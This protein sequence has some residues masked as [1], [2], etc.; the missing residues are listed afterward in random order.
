MKFLEAV[1]LQLCKAEHPALH[2]VEVIFPAVRPVSPFLQALSRQLGK[3]SLA[4]ACFAL[5]DWAYRRSGLRRANR[6]HLISL[7]HQAYLYA[8]DQ[9]G[10]TADTPEQ[11]LAWA[12]GLLSDFEEVDAYVLPTEAHPVAAEQIFRYLSQQK[13]VEI[14]NPS[15]EE[16]SQAEAE[17]LRFYNLI[18]PTYLEFRRLLETEKVDY[19]SGALRK[20]L[21]SLSES[22]GRNDLVDAMFWVGFD[23]VSPLLQ[24]II[25]TLHSSTKIHWITDADRYY[26]DNPVHLA[27]HG[28]RQIPNDEPFAGAMPAI[29]RLVA[30]IPQLNQCSCTGTM[31]EIDAGIDQIKTWLASGVKPRQIGWVL[32]ESAQ[33][34]P[35]LMRWDHTEI[36][37][38]LGMPIDLRWTLSYSWAMEYLEILQSLHFKGKVTLEDWSNWVNNPIWPNLNVKSIENQNISHKRA[39][40]LHANDLQSYQYYDIPLIPIAAEQSDLDLQP[41]K[42]SHDTKDKATQAYL[43]LARIASA[44]INAKESKIPPME[45]HALRSLIT[46]IKEI[47]ARLLPSKNSWAVWRKMWSM[48]LSSAGLNPEGDS[49]EGIRLMSLSDTLA[50]DFD[51]MV[52]SGLNEGVMPR[53][54]HYKGMLSFDLRRS[55]GLPESWIQEAHQTYAFYRLL[56]HC[57][58]AK[59]LYI[60]SGVGGKV[61]EKSR[62]LQ[63]LDLEYDG[64]LHESRKELPM[65]FPTLV[66]DAITITKTKDVL[67]LILQKLH[68]KSI[69]PSYLSSYLICP[70]R[71][72]FAFILELEKP[73]EIDDQL[74]P[75]QIGSLFHLTLE[76]LFENMEGKDLHPEHWNALIEEI[77]RAWAKACS[78]AEF[79]PYSFDQGVNVMVKRMGVQ[80]MQDYLCSESKRSQTER[81]RLLGQE[82]KFDQASLEVDGISIAWRGR[83]DRLESN[84][85]RYRIVDFKSGNMPSNSKELELESLEEALDGEHNKAFQLLCYAWLAHANPQPQRRNKTNLEEPIALPLELGIVPLQ[86]ASGGARLLKVGGQSEIDQPTIQAFEDLLLGIF[87]EILDPQLPIHQTEEVDRCKYCDFNRICR[88]SAED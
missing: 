37:L 19:P 18:Y 21:D 74:N 79:K 72:W 1:A 47:S 10:S 33:V 81:I 2:R 38:H 13:A 58:E 46:L 30:G 22:D 43:H 16:P 15:G 25:E 73:E 76:I 86:Q 35:L 41:N 40:F 20:L 3:P 7:L 26:L 24:K 80:I 75:R 65:S 56:Q 23:Q 48:H 17:Y 32:C 6:L 67:D 36:G 60:H 71:F 69:N 12:P 9:E 29:D 54:G 39:H 78:H 4:P 31:E 66:N 53:P 87:R 70:L 11:F 14:W 5:E 84:A 85:G 49:F 68:T 88:R 45:Q 57:T 82:L 62:F 44:L 42:H 55:F 28:L 61:G 8:V 83:L 50:M 63:Q 27:G 77:P 52:F 64:T 34:W 59:L 51:Y